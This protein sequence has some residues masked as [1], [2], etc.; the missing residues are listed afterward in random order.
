MHVI[1]P[2]PFLKLTE[3][4]MSI[5]NTVAKCTVRTTVVRTQCLLFTYLNIAQHRIAK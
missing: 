2:N 5:H 3:Y 4:T 1:C